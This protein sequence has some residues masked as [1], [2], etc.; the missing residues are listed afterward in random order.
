M[1]LQSMYL[2][3]DMPSTALTKINF[4]SDNLGILTQPTVIG[5]MKDHFTR[6]HKWSSINSNVFFLFYTFNYFYY[7]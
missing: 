3:V 6:L 1:F 4:I 2:S 5:L 7:A